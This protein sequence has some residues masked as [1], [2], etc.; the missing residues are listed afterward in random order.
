MP[1]NVVT[2]TG[3]MVETST[4]DEVGGTG[5]VSRVQDVLVTAIV[6]L[7]GTAVALGVHLKAGFDVVPALS[8]GSGLFIWLLSAHFLITRMRLKRLIDERL[9]NLD[10]DVKSLKKEAEVTELLAEGHN[11]LAAG[12]EALETAIKLIAERVDGYDQKL[13]AVYKLAKSDRATSKSGSEALQLTDMQAELGLLAGEIKRLA[14]RQDQTA[15][16]Q[17]DLLRAE[18]EV[19]EMVVR[20]MAVGADEPRRAFCDR[21]LETLSGM[22]QLPLLMKID[23]GP[24]RLNSDARK[25]DDV[26]LAGL[27]S[28]RLAK[29]QRGD[30]DGRDRDRSAANQ[31]MGPDSAIDE[32]AIKEG[33]LTA[34]N[35]AIEA[36]R[37]ELYMQPVVKL[38]AR[39]LVYYESLA[40]L[41]TDTGQLLDPEVYGE[42]TNKAGLTP[43]I[44]NQIILMAIQVVEKLV[45]RNKAKK[46]FCS[47]SLASLQDADFFAEFMDFMEANQWLAHHLVFMMPQA[48][49]DEAGA[50]EMERIA[51]IANLGFV[52]G[53]D[54][55]ERLNIDFKTVSEQHFHY[56]KVSADLLLGNAAQAGADIHPAD[57]APYL[58]RLN[59]TLIVDQ[60][61]RDAVVRQL[62]DHNVMFAQGS[63]FCDPKPVRS[64]VFQARAEN[65]A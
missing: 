34:V 39:D 48:A 14:Q 13:K 45:A 7:I 38:P 59:M 2:N 33:L 44:D 56:I 50:Y 1:E 31:E 32:P 58:N 55:V 61:S 43:I 64:D 41:R 52:F 22:R 4:P 9:A 23:G 25:V 49:L 62:R 42:T 30:G 21:A 28:E 46:I 60:V 29:S 24:G 37:I 53:I 57:L 26:A 40:R 35:E 20:Q 47:L 15:T 36:D 51:D 54:Q 63:L 18:L 5:D 10:R 6:A 8:V 11:D 19:L 16:A 3:P 27:A 17:L 65:A 12:Q